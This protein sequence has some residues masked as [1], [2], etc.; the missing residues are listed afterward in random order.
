MSLSNSFAFNFKFIYCS[1]RFH[2]LYIKTPSD[3]YNVTK[4][5]LLSHGGGTLIRKYN[6]SLMDALRAI[7]PQYHWKSYRFSKPHNVRRGSIFSKTQF[8]LFK[9]IQR[10]SKEKKLFILQ[11]L[12]GYVVALNYRFETTGPNNKTKG[13]EFDVSIVIAFFIVKIFSSDLALAFEYNGE[14]HYKFVPM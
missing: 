3:W 5:E 12:P 4:T 14:N 13:I 2:L 8:V 1:L 9:Y 6:N 10:V 11:L 7:Y